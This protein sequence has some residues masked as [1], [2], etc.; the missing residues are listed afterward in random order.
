[1]KQYEINEST[2]AIIACEENVSKIY[3]EDDI[4]YVSCNANKIMEN[5]CLYFGSSLEGRKKGT[6]NLIGINYKPPLIVEET[7]EIIFFPTSSIR[8]KNNNWISLAHID[9]YYKTKDGMIIKFK[10]GNIITLD[11]SY[12]ILDNQ[13]LRSTRLESALRGRKKSKKHFM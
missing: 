11:I 4:F 13:V 8:N 2:Q 10:N 1:M 9:K 5:S 6:E 3:E 12:G 7:K